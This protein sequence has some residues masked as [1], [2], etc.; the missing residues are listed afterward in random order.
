MQPLPLRPEGDRRRPIAAIRIFSCSG[1]YWKLKR[2]RG[3]SRTCD[4]CIQNCRQGSV[5]RNRRAVENRRR[6]RFLGSSVPYVPRVGSALT[7]AAESGSACTPA[8]ADRNCRLQRPCSRCKCS[9]KLVLHAGIAIRF[10]SGRSGKI[11]P[12][13]YVCKSVSETIA[14]SV[15]V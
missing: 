5:K 15:P 2:C 8:P 4:G 11:V 9:R 6:N 10:K 7:G 3:K 13:D 14:I 12:P 1:R